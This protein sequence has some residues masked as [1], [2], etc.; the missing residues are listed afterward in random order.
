MHIFV[1]GSCGIGQ[2]VAGTT[3]LGK[4]PLNRGGGVTEKGFIEAGEAICDQME[5]GGYI[6]Q[7]GTSRTF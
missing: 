5:A 3:V 1:D 2:T 4:K 7:T 6:V